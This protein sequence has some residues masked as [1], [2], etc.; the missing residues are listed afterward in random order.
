MTPHKGMAFTTKDRDNDRWNKNCATYYKGGWWYEICHHSNLNGLYL[1]G[2]TD[3]KGTAWY[4]WK[5]AHYSVKKATMKIR[6]V[7]FIPSYK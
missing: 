7:N 6:P 3:A 2:G 1:H 4:K 5:N